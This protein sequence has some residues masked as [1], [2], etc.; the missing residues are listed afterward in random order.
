VKVAE[1]LC[2]DSSER[3]GNT[4]PRDGSIRNAVRETAQRSRTREPT[5]PISTLG[6]A[7]ALFKTERAA[8]AAYFAALNERRMGDVITLPNRKFL[9]PGREV[10]QQG[11]PRHYLPQ[12]GAGFVDNGEGFNPWTVVVDAEQER[13]PFQLLVAL[14]NLNPK[15]RQ[16]VLAARETG[17]IRE[18]AA[19]V[20][21]DGAT[22]A[23]LIPRLKIFLLP[24]LR[25]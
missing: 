16:F 18:A 14:E 8:R 6:Y 4:I 2:C 11:E 22:V 9:V 25:A 7:A 15:V 5:P 13:C 17:E 19:S 12:W 20:G 1:E 21:F 24:Y 3:R 10:I 23:K